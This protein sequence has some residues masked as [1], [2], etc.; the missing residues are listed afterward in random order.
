MF[1]FLPVFL[2]TRLFCDE[3][4]SCFVLNLFDFCKKKKR[5][6]FIVVKI[7]LHFGGTRVGQV[8][9]VYPDVLA[10]KWDKVVWKHI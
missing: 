3:Q 2:K 10:T 9:I 6:V 5:E 8:G 4:W 7:Y 1:P